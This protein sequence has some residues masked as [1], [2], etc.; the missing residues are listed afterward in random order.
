MSSK[1]KI[2]QK[3]LKIQYEYSQKYGGKCICLMK[4]R[5]LYEAY[6]IGNTGIVETI[7]DTLGM[8]FSIKKTLINSETESNLCM[9]DYNLYTM[10][11]PLRLFNKY[12]ERLVNN[13]FTVIVIRRGKRNGK[14]GFIISRI[15]VVYYK[16]FEYPS[17]YL[18]YRCCQ[19]ILFLKSL[20]IVIF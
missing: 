9:A 4:N 13:N 5:D 7:V 17:F 16:K 6:Y 12:K 8:V 11:F 20:I 14:R 10:G 1:R 18:S 15:G 3:Y 2:L 19:K